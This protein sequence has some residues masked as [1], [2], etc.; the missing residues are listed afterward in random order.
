MDIFNF[1]AFIFW[2]ILGGFIIGIALL[3]RYVIKKGKANQ[4]THVLEK[5]KNELFYK[6]RAKKGNLIPWKSEHL[7]QISNNLD[8]NYVQGITRKFNG[9]IKTLQ[10]ER[11]LA[12]RRIDRG[13]MVYTSRF[14]ALSNDFELYFSQQQEDVEIHL[15]SEYYGK[16][17]NQHKIVDR[18]D[19]VIGSF[20]RNQ[21]REPFY[22]V[23]IDNKH[24][25]DIVKNSERRNI[26]P[27]R[28]PNSIRESHLYGHD[29][30]HS[31]DTITHE[32]VGLNGEL[33]S[34]EYTWVLVLTLYE[35]IF[36]GIDFTN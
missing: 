13:N 9:Y 16:I 36:Y 8:F 17:L 32:L 21:T 20:D 5:E 4:P 6:A 28:L 33:N 18:H 26:I 27:N 2:L 34:K 1:F 7:D 12:F 29:V 11:L 30:A 23:H 15:N 31:N 14:I 24:C 35:A 19:Q 25:A 3:I 22:A 10:G